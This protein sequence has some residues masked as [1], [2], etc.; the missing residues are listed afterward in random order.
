MPTSQALRLCPKAVVVPVPRGACSRL[1]REI[2]G[3][4]ERWTP[5]LSAASIDEF[6][7]DMSGTERL[8]R[9]APLHELATRIREEVLEETRI[10][11]SVGGATSRLVAKIAVARAK[12][13]GVHVVE[14]GSEAAFL[15]AFPLRAIP[16]IGPKADERLARLGLRT[17]ADAVA[18]GQERLCALLG[19][20]YG[21][22]LW[23]RAHG[24]DPT[25]VA[26]REEARSISRDETFS[27][28]IHDDDTLRRELLRLVTRAAGDMRGEGLRARTIT[29][30]IRDFDFRNRSASRTLP[31]AVEADRAIHEAACTL[32]ARLRERRNVPARLISVALTHLEG[33]AAAQIGLFDDAPGDAGPALESER[34]RRIAQTLDALRERHGHDVIRPARLVPPPADRGSGDPR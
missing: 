23:R 10:S 12:P 16:G 28:D 24:T 19:R 20:D 26:E 9:D 1:H 18:L 11:V 17:I 15:S 14:P 32:L 27:R 30:R 7:L 8:Y 31:D 6:Y 13:G 2:R 4:L 25:P 33:A 34:E 5:A 21:L 22:W 29:V 3:V